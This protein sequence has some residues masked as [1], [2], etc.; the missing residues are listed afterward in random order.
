MSQLVIQAI[1][2]SLQC[3][4]FG[5]PGFPFDHVNFDVIFIA[6]GDVFRRTMAF[7]IR[8]NGFIFEV[9]G[10]LSIGVPGSYPSS[11]GDAILFLWFVGFRF[12]FCLSFLI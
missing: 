10:G 5:Y 9:G 8:I 3:S 12:F 7:I 4:S 11:S 1:C 6:F 2:F